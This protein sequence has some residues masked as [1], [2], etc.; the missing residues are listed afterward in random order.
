MSHQN[1]DDHEERVAGAQAAGG[2]SR[3]AFLQ[4]TGLAGAGAAAFGLAAGGPATPALAASPGGGKGGAPSAQ[5]PHGGTWRP[6]TESRQFTLAVMPDTQFLYFDASLRPEPQ[7]ASFEYVLDNANPQGDNIV[8]MAHL[9][10]LTE[11]GLA[12]EFAGV[13]PVFDL[14][15]RG[16]AAYSVL[17]GNHDV[18]SST[19]DTRGDTPYL[20]TMGP[21]RFAHSPS[22][23]GATQDGYNTYHVFRAAGRDWLL[24][25]MDWRPSAGGFAWA[26]QVVKNHPGMPVILTTH[27]IATPTYT[28]D[29]YPEDYGDPENDA[30]LSDFGQQMWDQL[31]KDN[32]QVFLTLNGHYWPPG[33]TTMKNTA[34]NDVH[35]HITNYQNRYYGGAAMMRLYHFDLDR[36]TIDVE[37][38]APWVLNQDA[39]ERNKLAAQIARLTGPVDYFS[40]AIDFEQRFSGFIPVPVRPARPAHRMVVPG[41]LAYWRFDQGGA[42]G[43]PFTAKQTVPDL[44]GHGNDLSVLVTV[45]GSS[46]TALT[47]SGSHHPDQP[48]HA[49]LLFDGGQN[50]LHGAYLTTGDR[51]PLNKETFEHGFTVEAFVNVPTSWTSADNSWQAIVSRWGES[52]QAGK[53]TG[54]TDPQEPIV[55]LSLSSG[56][57]PQWCVYPTN[58]PDQSTNW[59]QAL[60]MDAWWHVAVVNDGHRTVL[61]VE[62]CETVDNPPTVAIGLTSLGLPWALGG[63]EYGGSI[64]QIFHGSIGDVRIV[65]RPLKPAEFM[66]GK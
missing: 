3:R 40:V 2:R 30:E 31:I 59:G 12:S 50:P 39:A 44:S 4:T 49:S 23:R 11:D 43:T 1:H 27:E 36:D 14:L 46:A 16:G 53:S 58:L 15:D 56:R 42:D 22:F 34:G 41:T 66:I 64:N 28:D 5:P 57:E 47:W 13:D 26:N 18:N 17:A 29:T 45:P 6:D 52:G 63:Y 10:D 60:P 55:T 19:D 62:G 25:A 7:Q 37:T 32:D 35:V 51:A 33:R 24:L 48:G 8:F 20:D 61:Y 38:V 9:G 54:N 21:K 65:N